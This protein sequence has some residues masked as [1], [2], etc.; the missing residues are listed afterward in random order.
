M[1]K[2]L[3]LEQ[4]SIGHTN[5]QSVRGSNLRLVAQSIAQPLRQ[6]CLQTSSNLFFDRHAFDLFLT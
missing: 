6:T 3:D 5:V 2:H 1:Q 4:L